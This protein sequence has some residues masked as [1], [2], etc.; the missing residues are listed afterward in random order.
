MTHF[1][2]NRFTQHGYITL[3]NAI[4]N[5]KFIVCLQ[6]ADLSMKSSAVFATPP[7]RNRHV[8]LCLQ[9]ESAENF[10]YDHI[11]VKFRFIVPNKCSVI[12]GDIEGSTHS[13]WRQRSRNGCWLIGFCHE[14]NILCEHDYQFNGERL[15]YSLPSIKCDLNTLSLTP[16]PINRNNPVLKTLFSVRLNPIP[17]LSQDS[18]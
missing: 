18:F 1:F 16:S 6:F 4:L 11:H 12:D 3:N 7:H 17:R 9:I 2:L 15:Q 14:L 8:C 5:V 10:S 13:T